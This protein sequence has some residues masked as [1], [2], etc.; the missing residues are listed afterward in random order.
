MAM[1]LPR[2]RL[3]GVDRRGG[4]D[5]IRC[6]ADG[7]GSCGGDADGHGGDDADSCE[8]ADGHGGN[9]ANCSGEDPDG[10]GGDDAGS[11]GEDAD[12]HGSGDADGHGCEGADGHGSDGADGHG[13]AGSECHGGDVGCGGGGANRGGEKSGCPGEEGT[14][15]HGEAV[16]GQPGSGSSDGKSAVGHCSAVTS[17]PQSTQNRTDSSGR[18]CPHDGHQRATVPPKSAPPGRLHAVPGPGIAA[19]VTGHPGP[20]SIPAPGDHSPPEQDSHLEQELNGVLD[21]QQRIC[22]RR[23]VSHPRHQYSQQAAPDMRVRLWPARC[24]TSAEGCPAGRGGRG[25]GGG[26]ETPHKPQDLRTGGL[27]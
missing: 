3:G 9:D 2:R 1:S 4:G 25:Q 27:S 13:W 12:G 24:R 11:C 8:G 10:H 18:G 14:R 15:S 23:R 20:A 16:G 7:A 26:T 17:V 21:D 5:S 19:G 22:N 6:G